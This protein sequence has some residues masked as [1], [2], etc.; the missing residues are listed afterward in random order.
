MLKEECKNYVEWCNK[1]HLNKN[2]YQNLFLFTH[3]SD[4]GFIFQ[5]F[6]EAKQQG[7]LSVNQINAVEGE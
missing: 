2:D 3:K 6:Q 5:E 7:V 1:H 4:M